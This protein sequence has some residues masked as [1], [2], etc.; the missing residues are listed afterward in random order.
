MTYAHREEIYDADSHMM[1][2]PNWIAEF[3][4]PKIRPYL[5]P[6]VGGRKETLAEID[7]AINRFKK[8]Q[9]NQELANKAKKEFKQKLD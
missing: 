4:D 8:R 6:F 5:E 7:E 9:N 1:E 3:A 2:M